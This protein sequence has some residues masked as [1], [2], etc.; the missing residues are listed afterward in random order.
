MKGFCTTSSDSCGR[1]RSSRIAR[2]KRMFSPAK[3]G[4]G[5]RRRQRKTRPCSWLGSRRGRGRSGRRA[6]RPARRRSRPR[7]ASSRSDSRRCAGPCRSRPRSRST[8]RRPG[9]RARRRRRPRAGRGCTRRGCR[10]PLRRA[11]ACDGTRRWSPPTPIRGCPARAAG[12]PC[13]SQK[14]QRSAAVL[15]P[16]QSRH[17]PPL[18]VALLDAARRI[19]RKSMG[20]KRVEKGAPSPSSRKEGPRARSRLSGSACRRTP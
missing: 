3:G 6:R 18:H 12:R 4:V 5:A 17:K 14:P 15:A 16:P 11:C 20:R 8:C 10:P 13:C 1:F 19:L 2:E 7:A 9:G